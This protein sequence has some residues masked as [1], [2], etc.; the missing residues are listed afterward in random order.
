[1]KFE[2]SDPQQQ[3]LKYIEEQGG[4]TFI[5]YWMNSATIAS[6]IRRKAVGTRFLKA[7]VKL[8]LQPQGYFK[9]DYVPCDYYEEL[10]EV[11]KWRKQ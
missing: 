11:S 9:M 2:A 5:A 7:G 10:H 6:L 4:V 1:M 8:T 3:L